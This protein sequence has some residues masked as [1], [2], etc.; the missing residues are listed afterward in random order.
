[1][2]QQCIGI[3]N[4]DGLNRVQYGVHF[5]SDHNIRDAWVFTIPNTI[6]PTV[7]RCAVI[8]SVPADDPYYATEFGTDGEVRKSSGSGWQLM[9]QVPELGDPVAVQQQA[10]QNVNASLKADGTLQKKG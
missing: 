2:V 9:N 10:P 4:A 6:V 5:Y 3:W 7:L 1:V 8:F